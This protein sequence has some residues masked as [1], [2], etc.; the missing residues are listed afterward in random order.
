MN[1]KTDHAQRLKKLV[2]DYKAGKLKTYSFEE[3][4][5]KNEEFLRALFA[6]REKAGA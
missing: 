6:K 1:E 2:E 4:K 5:K 3:S